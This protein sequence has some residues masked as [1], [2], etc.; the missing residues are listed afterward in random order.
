MRLDVWAVMARHP[1]DGR[2]QPIG[3]NPTEEGAWNVATEAVDALTLSHSFGPEHMRR[4][5]HE[6]CESIRVIPATLQFEEDD[7]G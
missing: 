5:A 6:L 1:D 7:L 2:W 3:T 4:A